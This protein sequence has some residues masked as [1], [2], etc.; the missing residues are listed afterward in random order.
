MAIHIE[1]DEADERELARIRAHLVRC[2]QEGAISQTQLAVLARRSEKWINELEGGVGHPHMSSLQQ[3]AGMFNLRLEPRFWNLVEWG[4]DGVPQEVL[5]NWQMSY[6]ASRPFR[7]YQWQRVFL[8]AELVAY[9][10]AAQV[11]AAELSRRLGR[12][13]SAV[14]G[15]ERDGNDPLV[16]KVFT[17]VRALGGSVTFQFVK[18]ADWPYGAACTESQSW[19]GQD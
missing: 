13:V 5:L 6:R 16:S 18:E 10:H 19:D 1:I 2:R 15:W 11:S 14:S 8:V 9:R 3:W 4:P 12:S 17:Y 7:A